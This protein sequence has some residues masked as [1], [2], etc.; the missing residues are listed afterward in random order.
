MWKILLSVWGS[1]AA[2]IGISLYYTHDMR[3][4]W[5]LLI[6]ALMSFQSNND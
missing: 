3:C 6:P 4:L 2:A 1:T 5:F